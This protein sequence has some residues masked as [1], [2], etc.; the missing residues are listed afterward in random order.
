MTNRR[1]VEKGAGLIPFCRVNGEVC[2]LFHKTFSGRRAGSLVDFGGGS[3]GDESHRQTA[4][5]EFIEETE[6][7]FFA[8]DIQT[9]VRTPEGIRSQTTILGKLFDHT[10]D[11]HPEW[12]CRRMSGTKGGGKDWLTFFIAFDYKDVEGMNRVWEADRGKRFVKRRELI[13]VPAGELMQILDRQPEMLWKRLRKLEH[14]E[15]VVRAIVDCLDD[16]VE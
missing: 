11:A 4:I 2:F 15:V 13:W 9:A 3:D 16:E 12:R 1:E 7:L 10:Q 6:T 8:D 14:M 5:R